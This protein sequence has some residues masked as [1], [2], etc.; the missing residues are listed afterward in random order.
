MKSKAAGCGSTSTV[1][2]SIVLLCVSSVIIIINFIGDFAGSLR[3]WRTELDPDASGADSAHVSGCSP[4]LEFDTATS[5]TTTGRIPI[6]EGLKAA[7]GKGK[8]QL[9]N[10]N[11]CEKCNDSDDDEWYLGFDGKG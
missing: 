8:F 9:D 3:N 7:S 1:I 11:G 5:I 2:S 4:Q 10:R 6:L